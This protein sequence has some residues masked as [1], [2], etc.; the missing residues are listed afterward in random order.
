MSRK[1]KPSRFV[2]SFDGIGVV[3]WTVDFESTPEN[4]PVVNA[5]LEAGIGCQRCDQQSFRHASS[6]Y[7][8]L[9]RHRYL[10]PRRLRWSETKRPTG[11][12]LLSRSK[13]SRPER[14]SC[15]RPSFSSASFS[16]WFGRERYCYKDST[17]RGLH[18]RFGS[19][20]DIRPKKPDVRF[21]PKS[22]HWL[23]VPRCPLCAKCGHR[24]LFDHLVGV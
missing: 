14:S 4:S 23:S 16:R 18:V 3:V 17:L 13:P 5:Q 7:V 19:K 20:A 6:P 11:Q 12:T 21:T 24:G 22:G 1:P 15:V 8:G 2:P 10:Q 9:R